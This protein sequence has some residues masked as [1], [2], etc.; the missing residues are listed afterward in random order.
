M[1]AVVLVLIAVQVQSP[2]VDMTEGG[3]PGHQHQIVRDIQV[4]SP[5]VDTT[6]VTSTLETV[7]DT[8]ADTPEEIASL[9]E[10]LEYA[11][12]WSICLNT[13][14][15]EALR[16]IP[17]LSEPDV[18]RILAFRMERGK[19]D[20]PQDLL[21][22]GLSEATLASMLPFVS[23][24][25]PHG[26]ARPRVQADLVQR[27]SRRLDLGKGYRQDPASGYLGSP[28][29]LQWRV[30][31]RIG[32]HA[33]GGIVLDKD[34]GEPLSWA[35]GARRFGPDFASLHARMDDVGPLERVVAGHY[36]VRAGEGLAAGHGMTSLSALRV[37]STD[38]L[39]RPHASSREHA[40]FRGLA[41]QSKPILGL[42]VSGFASST[43]LDA[44]VDTSLGTWNLAAPGY[45]RTRT[46]NAKRGAAREHVLGGVATLRRKGAHLGLISL[47]TW[48]TVRSLGT[49]YS[50]V[51]SLFA[52]WARPHWAFRIEQ[53][54]GGA[55]T[56]ITASFD[57]VER[58]RIILG[59]RHA[60][61]GSPSPHTGIRTNARS[62]SLRYTEW[63][64]QCLFEPFEAWTADVR[65]RERRKPEDGLPFVTDR[66]V[67]AS[68]KYSP[69]KWLTL[70]LRG[71]EQSSESP[72]G[73]R[74][75]RMLLRCADPRTRRSLRVQMDYRHSASLRSRT[76]VEAVRARTKELVEGHGV[77]VYQDL[78]WR[79]LRFIQ[80]DLRYA[81][82]ETTDSS[83]RLYV[84]END[85]LYG[86]SAPSFSGRGRRWYVLAR[87]DVSRRLM[88]Q[89]RFGVTVYED[90]RS[91]G[92]GRDEV[93]GNRMRE[94]KLLA[95]WKLEP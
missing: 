52:G 92:S 80:L 95:R 37:A 28:D 71:T 10:T 66:Q 12:R 1:K 79:L 90:Q 62:E 94:L 7:L 44:R 32:E 70:H 16:S 81:F 89:A 53:V 5:S 46:E 35:P 45:H 91:I 78:R 20:D 63:T 84:Y 82:F 54:L 2:P 38:R 9:Q 17:G 58:A 25:K 42:S 41:I 59:I 60:A 57:P 21:E 76:R 85:V 87:F 49:R 24:E 48:H 30:G 27:W 74:T 40:H 73:C 26:R 67:A 8:W 3:A 14:S 11:K 15:A 43:V 22:A 69:R 31:I 55:H 6:D 18:Q 72:S 50:P 65:L 33:A 4:Q 68:I 83:A 36:V 75:D 51:L 23:F 39:L 77:L 93:P 86:F 34:A 47:S 56:S 64:A 13:A 61:G 19:I 88:M 29:A